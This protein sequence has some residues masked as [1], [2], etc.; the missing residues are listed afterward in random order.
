MRFGRLYYWEKELSQEKWG[1][2]A[3]CSIAHMPI[4]K[5]Q[6][7]PNRLQIVGALTEAGTICKLLEFHGDGPMHDYVYDLSESPMLDP[8]ILVDT[9]GNHWPIGQVTGL[10]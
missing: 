7:A 10:G 9:E 5:T 2:Q 6:F 1:R 8:T 3:C 4:L